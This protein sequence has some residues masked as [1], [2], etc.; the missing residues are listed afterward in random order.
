MEV[1]SKSTKAY[2]QSDK[3]DQYRLLPSGQH[4]LFVSQEAVFARVYFR[5]SQPDQWVDTDYR[6]LTDTI[7][8]G[9]LALP[10]TKIYRKTP[11]SA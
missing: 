7:Q 3:L 10:M 9:D 5:T 8:L 2:D 4:I 1:L 6:Q 11:L